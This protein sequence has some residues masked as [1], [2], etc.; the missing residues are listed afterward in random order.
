MKVCSVEGCGMEHYARGW[1]HVH[2]EKLR[3]RTKC[4][5]EGCAGGARRRGLCTKHYSK[6]RYHGTLPPP[7]PKRESVCEVPGCKGNYRARGLC[8]NHYHFCQR[9]GVE[10]SA[11]GVRK[12]EVGR[13]LAVFE[14]YGLVS[15]VGLA[16]EALVTA[17]RG[18]A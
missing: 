2:Y 10:V 14:R 17:G 15:T 8:D 3:P 4:S 12:L 13:A 5:V 7:E 1:C 6:A 11:E 18:A 9:H 16:Q